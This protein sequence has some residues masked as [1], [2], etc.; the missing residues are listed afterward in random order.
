MQKLEVLNLTLGIWA[1]HH[2]ARKRYRNGTRRRFPIFFAFDTAGGSRYSPAS[3]SAEAADRSLPRRQGSRVVSSQHVLVIDG[4]PETEEV[5]KA[6]L[7]PRGLQVHRIRDKRD[8]ES[9]HQSPAPSILVIDDD[10]SPPESSQ[11]NGWRG[12][13]RVI[14]G[15]TS[16]PDNR[17][18][19]NCRH[20][21]QKPFQYAELIQ[22]IERLLA[23]SAT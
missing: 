9:Q 10:S 1:I 23:D 16:L 22:A 21:L 6:V 4:E 15:S 2:Q 20:I 8:A 13:P 17:P 7:E 11:A 14:I 3:I 12:V 19:D 18:R 5:L